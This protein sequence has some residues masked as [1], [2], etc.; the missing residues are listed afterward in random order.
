MANHQS[1]NYQPNQGIQIKSTHDSLFNTY[2]G[3]SQ[4]NKVDHK[5]TSQV[6]FKQSQ[7]ISLFL[8]QTA[9]NAQIF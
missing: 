8:V 9:I 5:Q 1:Y 3:Y 2:Q 4:Y 6:I 7:V